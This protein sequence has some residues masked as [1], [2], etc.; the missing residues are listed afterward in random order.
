[1]IKA[2]YVNGKLKE[3]FKQLDLPFEDGG[4]HDSKPQKEVKNVKK[5]KKK[6]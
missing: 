2:V 3:E 1:M 4:K 5:G 6:Q